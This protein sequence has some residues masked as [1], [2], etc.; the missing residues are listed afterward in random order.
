MSS[1]AVRQRGQKDKKAPAS[2][3]TSRELDR[4][5]N[6]ILKDSELPD[7]EIAAMQP[8]SERGTSFVDNSEG[9]VRL[10]LMD[11]DTFA[12]RA[13]KAWNREGA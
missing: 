9:G 4:D 11:D 1:P 2:A 10:N 5:L 8:Q 6:G 7:Q 3:S 12:D 13:S